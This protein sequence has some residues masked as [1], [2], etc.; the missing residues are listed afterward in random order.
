[1]RF[2]ILTIF[3]ESL[4]G[5]FSIGILGQAQA[6]GLIEVH[7]HDLREFTDDPH[8]IVDDRPYGGGPGM[9]M[10]VEPFVRGIEAI[11]GVRP[12]F[13]NC[14]HEDPGVP[15]PG[16]TQKRRP[17][18]EHMGENVRVI[19][20]SSQGRL[21]RQDDAIRFSKL[22]GLILLCGRYQGVDERV[23]AFA[24]EEISIGDYVLSGGEVAAAVIVEA[25]SRMIPGIVGRFESVK[26]DSFYA[27]ECLGPPQYTRPP[28][29][30]GHC[31]PEVLLSGDHL[32]IEA[33][34]E[35]KAWEKT[36]RNRPDL[37]GVDLD[38]EN[39]DG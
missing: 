25:T 27:K 26:E 3:P 34:R 7:L 18:P 33:F 35:R 13:L 6:K 1:M 39:A 14:T 22:D 31:V 12:S 29:F 23:L 19:L 11:S 32:K 15:H 10:K 5:F 37:L 20:L 8:R 30:R 36:T 38:K 4:S 16:A 17:D 21:F 24:D 2:D 28:L 9:V